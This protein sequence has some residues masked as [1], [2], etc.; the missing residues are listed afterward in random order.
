MTKEMKKSLSLVA[1]SFFLYYQESC[2][3]F[4]YI[5]KVLKYKKNCLIN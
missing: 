4:Y 5:V 2:N 1:D 3:T